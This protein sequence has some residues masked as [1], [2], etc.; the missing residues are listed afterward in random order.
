MND[1]QSL[2]DTAYENEEA[3][4]KLAIST[5]TGIISREV[6]LKNEEEQKIKEQ[7]IYK[8]G[9]LFVKQKNADAV[10]KLLTSLRAYFDTIPKART[11]KIVRTLID[12]V[13]KIPDTIQLQV[14]LCKESIAWCKDQRRTFLRQRIE[15]KL[16]ALYLETRKY[17]DALNLLS[18]LLREVKRL[19]DK[20][21]L[22]EIQLIESKVHHAVQNIPKSRAALTAARTSAN[23]I[24]CPPLLQASI[25]LQAGTLHAE[26]GDYKTGYSYFYEAFEAYNSLDDPKAVSALKYMLL[27]KIMTNASEEVHAIIQG[28]LALRYSGSSVDAM[29]QVAKAH[30]QRQLK[31]LEKALSDYKAE[32][33]DDPVIHRHLKNLYDNLLEQN[34]CRL[35]EPYSKVQIGHIASL[36]NLDRTIVE[37]KL[38]QMILDKQFSGILDQGAGCL[39]VFDDLQND[40]T[41]DKSLETIENMSKVVDTLYGR[42]AG[43]Y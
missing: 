27:C 20:Q 32:L 25:D 11:A 8:L 15:A 37:N 14:E 21:L 34:L 7:A 5:Y 41:Y 23:A 31:N 19:D 38:S 29:I 13:A 10:R 43:I 4:P 16:A 1:L 33:Q 6:D 17:P 18:T 12:L 42:A 26:E 36:I 22:V 30:S 39:I 3:N 28:K 24:Y 2:F 9:E 40:K 35:I